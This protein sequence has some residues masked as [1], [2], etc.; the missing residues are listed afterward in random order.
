MR[1]VAETLFLALMQ[2]YLVLQANWAQLSDLLLLELAQH[3]STH[4]VVLQ[5]YGMTISRKLNQ[6]QI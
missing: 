2:Q 5:V 1:E 3:A 4:I 6:L